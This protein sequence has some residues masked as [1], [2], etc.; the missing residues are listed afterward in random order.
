MKQ[1]SDLAYVI[2]LLLGDG[3]VFKSGGSYCIELECTNRSLVEDFN[4]RICD[5]LE[6]EKLYSIRKRKRSWG[7]VVYRVRAYSKALYRLLQRDLAEPRAYALTHPKAF[8]LSFFNAEGDVVFY[9]R[10]RARVKFTNTKLELLKLCK[11]VLER[12][13]YHPNLRGPYKQGGFG[14]KPLY[15]LCL[16]RRS[17]VE[18]FVNL[19]G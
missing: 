2:G 7:T 10:N 4:R 18:S 6:K 19:K 13:G 11:E 5:I 17:E 16:D 9:S 8:I 12:L 3:S 1:S 15:H 14:S